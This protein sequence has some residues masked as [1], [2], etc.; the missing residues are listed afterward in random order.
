MTNSNDKNF[1]NVKEFIQMAIEFEKNSA[2]FYHQILGYAQDAISEELISLL[3]AQEMEHVRILTDYLQKEDNPGMIQF[4]PSIQLSMPGLVSWEITVQKVMEVAM[5]RE[6]LSKEIYLEA[7]KQVKGRFKE[8]IEGL[9]A[10]EHEH[11]E[12]LKSLKHQLI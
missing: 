9:A 12:K 10:F 11:E 4:P 1:L 2:S 6:R 8:V 7:A 3:E 5:E